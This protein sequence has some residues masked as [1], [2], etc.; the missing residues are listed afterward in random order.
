M[1][2]RWP[3]L[4]YGHLWDLFEQ[5][6]KGRYPAP[7]TKDLHFNTLTLIPYGFGRHILD[8]REHI[9]KKKK[10]TTKQNTL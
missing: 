1:V 6:F 10:T 8:Y 9:V 3:E 2:N 4:F 7:V 5:Q